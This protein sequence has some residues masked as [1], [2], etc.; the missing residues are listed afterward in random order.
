M[1]LRINK[2]SFLTFDLYRKFKK[3]RLSLKIR[4]KYLNYEIFLNVNYENLIAIV[5]NVENMLL[6]KY[7]CS[8]DVE[9]D[10]VKLSFYQYEIKM[11]ILIE[12]DDKQEYSVTINRAQLLN[13]Y[14]YLTKELNTFSKTKMMDFNKKY[15]YVEVRYIDS[16]SSK[17]YAYISD[18]K[19]V[20]V[21]DVVYVDR[22]GTKCLA[23]VEEKDDYFYEEAPY[24]VLETKRVIKIVTRACEYKEIWIWENV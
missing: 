24:P 21:G 13:L 17:N 22:A 6:S 2:D 19:S 5:E 4:N 1:I 3:Y 11:K 8:R 12:L 18:D 14:N 9:L 7:R 15:T 20:R 10:R 23:V 16:Y